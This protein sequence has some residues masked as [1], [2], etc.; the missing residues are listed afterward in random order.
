MEQRVGRVYGTKPTVSVHEPSMNHTFLRTGLAVAQATQCTCMKKTLSVVRIT[1]QYADMEVDDP[2]TCVMSGRQR[3]DT[4]KVVQTVAIHRFKVPFLF[5]THA[6]IL[7]PSLS[8]SL[9][10]H[11]VHP[12]SHHFLHPSLSPPFTFSTLHF[13]L[14]PSLLHTLTYTQEHEHYLLSEGVS[15]LP[16]NH[17]GEDPFDNKTN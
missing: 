7:P 2:V 5:L 8:L 14:T 3:V 17:W 11:F 13:P 4:H 12:L 1:L 10:P 9:S 15:E 16:E 6:H